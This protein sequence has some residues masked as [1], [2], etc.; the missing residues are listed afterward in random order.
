ML[1]RMAEEWFDV[2]NEQDEVIGRAPRREVH[3]RRW[4]HRAVH[5]LVFNR[6]GEIFLQK[7]SHR[8]D[9]HPGVWDSSASGH[10]DS[11]EDYDQAAIRE[12]AEEIGLL[13]T[14]PPQRLFKIAACE[15]TG[16]EFVWVYRCEAE[17]PFQLNPEEI[18]TGRW[19]EPAAVDRWLAEAPQDFAPAFPVIWGQWR[20]KN[21]PTS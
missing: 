20:Q 4:R 16:M 9:N 11:G 1:A 19:F 12:A 6:R 7:R 2:V 8:K 17:G 21:P 15:A 3:A 13:M 5:L 14:Q 10:L 18:D